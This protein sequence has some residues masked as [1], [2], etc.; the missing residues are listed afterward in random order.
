M[1]KP[2]SVISTSMS[3]KTKRSLQ[4]AAPRKD[5]M[6]TQQLL[7]RMPLLGAVV[8]L[9]TAAVWSGKDE[10]GDA[11]AVLN[12]VTADFEYDETL[13]RLQFVSSILPESAMVF[14]SSDSKEDPFIIAQPT[15]ADAI[16]AWSQNEPW[17]EYPCSGTVNACENGEVM[18]IIENR[19]GAYTVRVLH[20]DA[21]ESIYSGMS[22][23]SVSEGDYIE[24]GSRIG[25][26]DD[27]IAFEVRKDGI[28]ILPLFDKK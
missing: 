22:S 10:T 6:A 23:I 19:E 16:H 11:L 18:S 28:S 27:R 25:Y 3:V 14:L 21:Y 1:E 13:G 8:L 5:N 17:F 20:N 24:I 2:H 4:N 7:K 26:A 9:L 15:S 12:N